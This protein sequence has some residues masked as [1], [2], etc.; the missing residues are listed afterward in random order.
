MVGKL[1]T[2][3]PIFVKKMLMGQNDVYSLHRVYGSFHYIVAE[4]SVF[5]DHMVCK[6]YNAYWLVCYRKSL[7]TPKWCS[8]KRCLWFLICYDPLLKF[9]H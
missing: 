5:K 4:W 8:Q 3:M 9:T 6:T 7:S 2:L 1:W